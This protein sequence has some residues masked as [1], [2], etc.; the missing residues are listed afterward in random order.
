LLIYES[1]QAIRMVGA[2]GIEPVTPAMSTQLPSL[3]SAQIGAISMRSFPFRSVLV[4]AN[5]GLTWGQAVFLGS[6]CFSF[7]DVH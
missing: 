7:Q 5:L 2:T 3:K 6:H 4:H 1:D